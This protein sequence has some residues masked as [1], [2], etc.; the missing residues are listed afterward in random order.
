MLA[1]RNPRERVAGCIFIGERSPFHRVLFPQKY[2][3]LCCCILYDKVCRVYNK[4][5][6]IYNALC[7]IEFVGPEN[8]SFGTARCFYLVFGA[9][10][11]KKQMQKGAFSEK[12]LFKLHHHKQ[13]ETKKGIGCQI[14]TLAP[15][16]KLM[17]EEYCCGGKQW[18]AV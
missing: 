9:F 18:G 2:T 11:Y 14:K 17:I 7:R 8:R 15:T 10:S 1:V 5:R 6:R 4:L 12:R 16:A 3:V 13:A